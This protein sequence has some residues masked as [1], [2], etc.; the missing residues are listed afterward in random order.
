MFYQ[1]GF[2]VYIYSLAINSMAFSCANWLAP[3]VVAVLG[4]KWTS[5]IGGVANWL[6]IS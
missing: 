2:V 5:F 3:S 6:V 4:N 1:Y